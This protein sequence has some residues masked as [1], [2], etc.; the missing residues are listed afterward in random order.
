MKLQNILYN[1]FVIALLLAPQITSAALKDLGKTRPERKADRAFIRGYYAR[2]MEL[3]EQALATFSNGSLEYMHLQIK[4][5]RLYMLLQNVDKVIYHY[6]QVHGTAADTLLAVSDICSYVD[7]LRLRGSNQEAEVV[8][9]FYAFRMPYSRNQRYINMLSALSNKQHYFGRG[10]SDFEVRLSD[11]SSDLPEYWVSEWEGELF[12]AVSHSPLQDPL[13]VFYHRTQYFSYDV[14]VQQHLRSIPRELQLGPIA[15]TSDK[16]M[17]VSTGIDYRK[18]DRIIDIYETR[19]F[20]NAQLYYSQ[21]DKRGGWSNLQPLFQQAGASYA[22]PIFFNNDRSL[23]FSSDRPGGYGGMDLYISHW[24]SEARTWS[25]PVNL[26]PSVNTEGDEIYPVIKD[27]RLFFSSNGHEGFGGYDLYSVR[28]EQ[29]EV[30]KGTLFHYP[31]PTNTASND[32]GIFFDKRTAYFISDRRGLEGGDDIYILNDYLSPLSRDL[33]VGVSSEY[34]AMTGNLND[35]MGLGR[36]M[37]GDRELNIETMFADAAPGEL[38]LS[39]YFDFNSY[40]FDS[41][42][43]NALR[44]FIS[45]YGTEQL[46]VVGYADE[47]GSMVFNQLLSEQR[48]KAVAN[49]LKQNGI[50]SIY[51]VEGRGKLFLTEE[52]FVTELQ[53]L[54]EVNALHINAETYS[55]KDLDGLSRQDRIRIN[56]KVRRVDIFKK[57]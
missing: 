1:L 9:R 34:S 39:I 38:L 15:F 31:Y 4:M 37:L 10:D 57:Q 36:N 46:H 32:F 48:A 6:S 7:A 24:N 12:Y 56:R 53:S 2:S 29:S 26:G 30:V 50:F 55:K 20:F 44:A 45:A 54:F 47:F 27:G 5:A 52:E 28:F 13:K 22:H 16:K 17:M 25:D 21:I 51:S 43:F 35:I 14:G 42:A 18:N 8:A 40:A 11:R 23:M 19:G 49:F 33:G 3:N 41:E